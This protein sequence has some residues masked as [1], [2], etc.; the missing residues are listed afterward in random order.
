VRRPAQAFALLVLWCALALADAWL[1]RAPRPLRPCTTDADCAER[2][3]G[4]D[5]KP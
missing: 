1:A 4:T 3:P 5:G 2:N